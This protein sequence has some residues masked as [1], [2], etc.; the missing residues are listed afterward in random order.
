MSAAAAAG[1]AGGSAYAEPP[2]VVCGDR[3][4]TEVPGGHAAWIREQ[5]QG[6]SAASDA[7][8]AKSRADLER[9]GS[10]R[11]AVSSQGGG[12]LDG[13]AEAAAPAVAAELAADAAAAG[14]PYD[15]SPAAGGDGAGDGERGGMPDPVTRQLADGVYMIDYMGYVSLVVA[16]G[17]DVMVTDP[18]NDVRAAAVRDEI[19]KITDSPV[20]TVVL[21]HEHYDHAGG[22]GIFEGAAVVCQSNCADLF[23]IEPF[24]LAPDSVDVTFD[25][26]LMLDVGGVVVELH[27]FGPADGE[28]TTVLY[29]PDE[30]ILY[31]ADLYGPRHFTDGIWMGDVTYP[32][33]RKVL[34]SVQYWPMEHAVNGH[35]P[36]TDP[37][38]LRESAGMVNA[39]YDAVYA[40]IS[41]PVAAGDWPALLGLLQDLPDSLVLEEYADWDGY[42]EHF[43]VHVYQMMMGM[44]HGD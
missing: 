42:D 5:S 35:S 8:T 28:A 43:P 23:D 9:V 24:G 18:A 2:R 3:L 7:D 27:Y 22:T 31:T 38:Y 16:S 6:S 12:G 17:D 33:V 20:T 11:E 25:D 14:M 41:G 19:A 44:V 4:C 30:Q 32:G 36:E 26:M 40:E 37:A 10:A 39:L 29:M 1:A 34:N 15:D 13:G 21:S